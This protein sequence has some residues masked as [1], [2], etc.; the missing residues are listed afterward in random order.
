MAELRD[1][2]FSNTGTLSEEAIRKYK[3]KAIEDIE[4]DLAEFGNWDISTPVATVA[5][6]LNN[7]DIEQVVLNLH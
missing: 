3:L 1:K 6:V 4:K 2:V 7:D 5:L